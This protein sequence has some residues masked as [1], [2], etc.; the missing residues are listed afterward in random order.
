[1]NKECHAIVGALQIEGNSLAMISLAQNTG[2]ELKIQVPGI[3]SMSRL[4]AVLRS[5][6]EYDLKLRLAVVEL[7]TRRCLSLTLNRQ[8]Y[9]IEK[10]IQ[11]QAVQLAVYPFLSDEHDRV[12]EGLQ[13][14]Q[15]I[16]NQK[17]PYTV[18]VDHVKKNKI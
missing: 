4:P 3:V 17:T 16:V 15:S 6:Q 8:L 12:H 14:A 18:W 2:F 7:V 11:D 10:T 1:M 13:K 9:P 5:E